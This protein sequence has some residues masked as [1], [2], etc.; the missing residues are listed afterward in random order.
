MNKKFIAILSGT[1]IAV[2]IILLISFGYRKGSDNKTTITTTTTTT[3]DTDD[4]VVDP[5]VNDT[6][7]SSVPDPVRMSLQV[8]NEAGLPS[9]L[10]DRIYQDLLK[11]DIT[12]DVKITSSNFNMDTYVFKYKGYTKDY[13]EYKSEKLHIVNTAGISGDMVSRLKSYLNLRDIYGNI[14]IIEYDQS[15]YTLKILVDGEEMSIE[16]WGQPTE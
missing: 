13:S 16:H 3:T 7:K 8:Y 6:S 14:E 10:V 12:G 1:V 4:Y 11:T 5:E 15:T 9:V 2:I